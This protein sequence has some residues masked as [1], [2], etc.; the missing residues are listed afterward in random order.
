MQSLSVLQ[1]LDPAAATR[2]LAAA[3]LE[4]GPF[5][6]SQ[7]AEILA[8]DGGKVGELLKQVRAAL[9]LPADD[10]SDR[11]RSAIAGYLS[12]AISD[13]ALAGRTPTDV[14]AHAGQE[15]RLP[16]SAYRVEWEQARVKAW[17][18]IGV[19]K[20]T[21]ERALAEPDDIEHLFTETELDDENIT[22]SLI[23]KYMPAKNKLPAHWLL[24]QA[25][26]RGATLIPQN[27]WWAHPSLVNLERVQTPLD[28]LKSFVNSFGEEFIVDGR[29]YLFAEEITRP[30]KVG[31]PA[32]FEVQTRRP[33]T[34]TRVDLNWSIRTKP[35]W[36]RFKVGLVYV[37]D[38]SR[39]KIALKSIGAL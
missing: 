23:T 28:M 26:R 25:M 33:L 13:L 7:E 14:L 24:V 36:D 17:R 2:L 9:G 22:F 12:S 20:T 8:E 21:V 31:A 39:Y 16:T 38:I 3:A 30:K 5:R 37:I 19:H 34:G 18:E 1:K 6:A 4:A 11:A 32:K 35:E 15:G 27:A 10:N 29:Q